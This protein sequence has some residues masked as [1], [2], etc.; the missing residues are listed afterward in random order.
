MFKV[1][2]A[3]D[4]PIIITGLKK[5]IDW[6]EH[7]MV[8]VGEAENGEQLWEL[9][10]EHHPDLVVTDINMPH[11][12]GL[13]YLKR[14]REHGM[15]TKVLF[16]S[17]YQEF[18]YAQEAIAFGAIGYIIKPI[19]KIQL[20][21]QIDKIS[22]MLN[23]KE[24]QVSQQ[25]ELA[26][27]KQKDKINQTIDLLYESVQKKDY[28]PPEF[29][30]DEFRKQFPFPMLT[31]VYIAIFRPLNKQSNEQLWHENEYKL[32]YFSVQNVIEDHLLN[33]V[34]GVILNQ[35]EHE[36]C[37][38]VNHHT[39]LEVDMLTENLVSKIKDYLKV[40]VYI[41][42]GSSTN[43]FKSLHLS[44]NDARRRM[45]YY[46]FVAPQQ[47]IKEQDVQT[48]NDR[49]TSVNL[50]EQRQQLFKS[51]VFQEKISLDEQLKLF[52]DWLRSIANG[53]KEIA[54]ST[55]FSVISELLD[56]FTEIGIKKKEDQ[57]KELLNDLHSLQTFL[58][59]KEY[60]TTL[61]KGIL[62]KVSKAGT[63]D[64]L[65]IKIVK[66]YI[67][68]NYHKNITLENIA[69]RVHMNPYYFS[70]FFKK[71]TN[72]N[73]K[74]YLT[75]HRMK[76]ALSLLLNS[77]LLIYEIAEKVGYQNVRQFSDMFKKYYG[78]SPNEY[79]K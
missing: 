43:E 33:D 48:T 63:I 41:G 36:F 37:V 56:E 31:I 50:T 61:T 9:T 44:Y 40:E 18:S 14:L 72:I 2:L 11:L 55:C 13:N 10:N 12:S 57:S 25:H 39:E 21:E 53:K 20:K 51:M 1:L 35:H 59:L 17:A 19:D 77:N 42:V 58:Q 45:D 52:F 7:E 67:E 66:D 74:K 47:I 49:V 24:V 78:K 26:K 70:S 30:M 32:L 16:I 27:Y 4:E 79:R 22:Q 62:V 71:H 8:I 6:E 46:Y 73:F 15:D 34:S 65:Q 69:A 54:V 28:N 60:V 29:E 76:K 38:L 3:D 23:E 5:I 64:N 68:D 75:K